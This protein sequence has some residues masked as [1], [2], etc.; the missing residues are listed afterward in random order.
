MNLEKLEQVKFSLFNYKNESIDDIEKGD[1]ITLKDNN[2]SL[3]CKIIDVKTDENDE[4]SKQITIE[5]VN[6]Q[7]SR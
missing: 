1:I 5:H 4:L 2:T 7:K 6:K 3:I